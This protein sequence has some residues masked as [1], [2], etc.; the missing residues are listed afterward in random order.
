MGGRGA[1]ARA[2]A[3]RCR[4]WRALG[5]AA[6]RFA[7]A[8]LRRPC[9]RSSS[10]RSRCRCDV[11]V[12][13][14]DQAAGRIRDPKVQTERLFQEAQ[15]AKR[16]AAEAIQRGDD[17]GA[18]RAYAAAGA[19]IAAAPAPSAELHEEAAILSALAER[20]AAGDGAWSA[21]TGRAE[22]ARKARQRGR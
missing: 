10:R 5:L 9:R 1:Q 3:S 17:D 4:R 6:D 21:K 2:L 19:A 13:P 15:E 18:L 11:N 20:T 22:H 16:K 7:G 12:V 14:G 8:A